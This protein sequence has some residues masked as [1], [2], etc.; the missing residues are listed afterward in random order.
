[1]TL[2]RRAGRWSAYVLIAVAM[3]VPLYLMASNAFKTQQDILTTPFGWPADGFTLDNIK[4]AATR[5]DYNMI[6]SYAV[7][8]FLVVAVNAL[9]LAV[10]GPAAYA[11]ARGVR[12]AHRLVMLVLL[13]GMFIPSQ[14]IMIPVIYVLKA[15]G[16]MHTLPG[17]I[18]FQTAGVIPATLFLMVAFVKSIPRDLDQAAKIDGAGRL[19]T[20]WQVIF[21]L[22]KPATA[23]AVILNAVIIWCDFI[24]PRI[25]LGPGS[26]IYTVTT[27]VYTAITKYTTDYTVVYSNIV[28]AVIPVMIFYVVLQRHIVSGITSGAVKA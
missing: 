21:P 8:A 24:G 2:A 15:I 25:I 3:L 20:F 27:G 11:I 12:R 17:L 22:M 18:L 23:T 6:S 19:R 4:T 28:L 7:T 9:C 14:V 26:G 13:A 16:L 1:M 10:T 5:T